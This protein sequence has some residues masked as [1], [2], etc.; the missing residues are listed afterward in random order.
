M[1]KKKVV[2][3][4]KTSAHRHKWEL[5]GDQCNVCDSY[6]EYCRGCDH[7]RMRNMVDGSKEIID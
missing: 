4:K 5:Y 2:V 7:T 3:K 6:E 1:K